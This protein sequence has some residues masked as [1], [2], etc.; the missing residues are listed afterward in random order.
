MIT[1]FKLLC[2]FLVIL[3]LLTDPAIAFCGFYVGGANAQLFN[4]ASQVIIARQGEKTVLTMVNDFQGDVKD[5]AIVVPVPVT[6]KRQQVNLGDPAIVERLDQ[7]SQPRL[8][9]YDDPTPCPRPRR[10]PSMRG[11]E[12]DPNDRILPESVKIEEQFQVGEYDISILGASDSDGLEA[13]LQR[14]NYKIPS[15]ASEILKPYIRQNMKFFVAKVNLKELDKTGSQTINPLQIAYQ[16]PKFMLPIRLGMLNAQGEQDLIV[17]LLSPKG[18]VELV[19]YRTVEIPTDKEIPEFVQQDFG[20]FY[21]TVFQKSYEL[22]SKKVA[23]LEYAWNVSNCDPC[24]TNPPNNQELKKAGV[25]WLSEKADD[26]VNIGS[27]TNTYITRLHLRYDRAHFAEDL[28]FQ[29]TSNTDTFQGR[30]VLRRPYRQKI[31]CSKEIASN[32]QRSIAARQQKE[33]QTLA[34]LTDWS[35]SEIQAKIKPLRTYTPTSDEPF[36]PW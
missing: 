27:A 30:Y 10:T 24:S 3:L 26:E 4:K 19:N 2:G 29:E 23:F 20:K 1:L 34:S 5:F 12:G 22:A 6:I 25:F 16:S 31:A 18:R 15:G 21:Q 8:V 14:N 35:L 33:A 13:W 36:W 28:I 7:F 9:D 32:Y 17:Y 11:S